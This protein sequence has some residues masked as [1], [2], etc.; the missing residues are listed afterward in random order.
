MEKTTYFIPPETRYELKL[1]KKLQELGFNVLHNEKLYGYYPDLLLVDYNL[2]IEVDGGI[3]RLKS[4]KKRDK[5]RTLILE[6]Y[7]YKVLRFTNAEVVKTLPYCI[8]TIRSVIS[9]IPETIETEPIK[10]SK[11]TKTTSR[12]KKAKIEKTYKE[13]V[14]QTKRPERRLVNDP[15]WEKLA[16]E[17]LGIKVKPKRVIIELK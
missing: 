3:H 11:T 17:K 14:K 5:Q 4:R 8:K 1:L 9:P 16:C 2:I 7:G 13:K 6:N 10:S 12:K 15:E